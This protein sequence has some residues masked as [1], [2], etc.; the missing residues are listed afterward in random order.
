MITEQ[1]AAELEVAQAEREWNEGVT[2]LTRPS[3]VPVSTWRAS[4]PR[5]Y[6]MSEYG[7]SL[8]SLASYIQSA[9]RAAS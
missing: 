9:R 5:D 1:Q 8:A 7:E 4:G 2:Y 3:S 6:T